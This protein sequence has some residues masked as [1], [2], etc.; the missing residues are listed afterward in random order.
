MSN[1]TTGIKGENIACEYLQKLGYRILERNKH[2]SRYCE[3]DILALDKSN[4][5]IAVEVKTRNSDICGSPFEA[6]TRKKYEN[7]KTGLFYYLQ[8]HPE[9]KK[10]QIDAISIVLT[11]KTTINHLK[12]I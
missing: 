7:I 9:Y 8:E 1:K 3:L 2:F 12:N 10:F 11:P 6:I 5:I 4:T